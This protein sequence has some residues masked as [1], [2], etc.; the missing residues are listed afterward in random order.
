MAQLGWTW[1]KLLDE[2]DVKT[3]AEDVRSRWKNDKAPND[4]IKIRRALTAAERKRS[5]P[6]IT[7]QRVL[8][9]EEWFRLGLDLSR[10]PMIFAAQMHRLKPLAD[11]ARE[12]YELRLA[13]AA[14]DRKLSEA[15]GAF[16]TPTSSTT[17]TKAPRK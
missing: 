17:R 13:A 10:S 8:G 15:E 2:A 12:S 4:R 3:R 5:Q 7:G 14:A 1:E 16:L 9:L 6:T 11:A